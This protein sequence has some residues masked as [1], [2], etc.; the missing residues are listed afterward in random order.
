MQK[1]NLLAKHFEAV[2]QP[3]TS[4]MPPAE[5]QQI[6]HALA[7]PGLPPTSLRPF[8]K[9]EMPLKNAS[10]QIPRI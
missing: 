10:G 8:K 2:F 5:D 9:T 1:A 3:Y 7:S 4:E 6:L